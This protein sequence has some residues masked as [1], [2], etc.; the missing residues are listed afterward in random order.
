MGKRSDYY[1]AYYEKNRERINAQRR[2]RYK[3]K[4]SQ[5]IA[6][7]Q[8]PARKAYIQ[9]WKLENRYNITVNCYDKLLTDQKGKCKICGTKPRKRKLAV[10]HCHESG[11]VRGLLCIKCNTAI[12]KLG[13]TYE[14]VMKAAKY[15]KDFENEQ[16]APKSS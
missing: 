1:K 6:R 4:T 13:D 2:E 5:K 14:G 15:L 12:G 8:Q 9:N 16:A 7:S 11:K 10:D 3:R